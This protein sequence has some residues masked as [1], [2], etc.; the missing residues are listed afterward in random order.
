MWFVCPRLPLD[1][2]LL[3]RWRHFT[4]ETVSLKFIKS[5]WLIK[6]AI[7]F[8]D[9]IRAMQNTSGLFRLVK[10]LRQLLF[11]CRESSVHH[12]T[13][14]T[15]MDHFGSSTA[16]LN[17]SRTANCSWTLYIF[18]SLIVSRIKYVWLTNSNISGDLNHLPARSWSLNLSCRPTF[19]KQ[20]WSAKEN[21]LCYLSQLVAVGFAII[22]IY[23][24]C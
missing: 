22:V 9:A 3:D 20:C 15:Q 12:I 23:Q 8:F 11:C 4:A 7:P 1:C 18:L 16:E 21:S 10:P 5:Q 13:S 2:C 17:R 19:R 24:E 14:R 6:A